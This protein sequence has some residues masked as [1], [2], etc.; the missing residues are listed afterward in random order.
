MPLIGEIQSLQNPHI[1]LL[2]RL[3]EKKRDRYREGQYLAEGLRLVQHAL[4]RGYRPAS[5]FYTPT[6]AAHTEHDALLQALD[7]QECRLWQVSDEVM[8]AISDTVTPQGLLA[9]L[10]MPRPD[11]AAVRSAHLALIVDGWRNP[12]NL[13]TLLR[14]ALATGVGAVVCAPGTVDP[15]APKVVRG[16][17]GAHLDLPIVVDLAWGEIGELLADRQRILAEAGA[18][19]SLWEI[20]WTLPSALI[21]GSE[22]HGPGR[23]AR[24]LATGAARIPMSE[25]AESLNAAIAAAGFLF[26]AQRQ[27]ALAPR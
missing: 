2:R 18:P 23:E 22:A 25:G 9:V 5:A 6:F 15:Y 27:R 13:G 1:K 24:A 8:A 17:M 16:G 12:G 7:A 19:L 21:I 26:E 14:T 11:P 10:P 4:S 3:R 20:D